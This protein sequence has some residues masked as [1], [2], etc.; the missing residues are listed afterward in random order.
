MGIGGFRGTM[1]GYMIPDNLD[2]FEQYEAEQERFTRLHKRQ[3]FEEHT[4][5]K[6]N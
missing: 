3:F 6:E 5:D 1:E 4:E 2:L